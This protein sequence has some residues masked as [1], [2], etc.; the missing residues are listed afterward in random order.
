MLANVRY[1]VLGEIVLLDIEQLVPTWWHE[2]L[3][4]GA[5]HDIFFGTD[6]SHTSLKA[7]R[8]FCIECPVKTDCLTH[9][10]ETPEEY[11]IW[12]G[13][14][15][16]NREMMLSAIQCGYDQGELVALVIENNFRWRSVR[17]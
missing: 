11:G 2:A 4:R 14:S 13:T 12:A 7:A 5:G 17:Q 8:E 16:R 9:A 6:E 3:C 10:L 15:A 1:T